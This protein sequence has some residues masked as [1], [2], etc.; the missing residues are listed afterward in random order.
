MHIAIYSRVSTIIQAKKGLS[1]DEQLRKGI[2]FCETNG[3]SYEL[4]KDSGYSGNLSITERPALNE[5]FTRITDQDSKNNSNNVKRIDGIFATAIDRISRNEAHSFAI[6]STLIQKE[7]KYFEISGEKD[8]KDKTTNLMVGVEMLLANFER[9]RTTERV[10]RG[11]E[12]SVIKGRVNSGSMQ[13]YGYTKG[14]DKLLIIDEKESEIVNEIYLMSLKGMGAK[15]ISNELNSRGVP[16]KRMQKEKVI[17]MKVRSIDK[18][19]FLWRDAVIY[20]ILTNSIYKGERMFRGKIYPAPVIIEPNL[21]DAVQIELKKRKHFVNTKTKYFYLLKGLIICGKCESRFFGKKRDDLSDNQYTCGSQRNKSEFCGNRGINID[22]LNDFVW[23]SLLS[24]PNDLRN[25]SVDDKDKYS[26][27]IIKKI[28]QL[29]HKKS[30]NDKAIEVFRRL[31][32]IGDSINTEFEKDIVKTIKINEN[33]VQQIRMAKVQLSEISNQEN[34]I[35]HLEDNLVLFHEDEIS[36][37]DKQSLIRIYVKRILVVW[38]PKI[39]QHI[40]S[41]DFILDN[42]S[43][44]MYEKIIEIKYNKSG[45]RYNENDLTYRFRKL[46]HNLKV[47]GMDTSEQK[48]EIDINTEGLG[49]RL[50]DEKYKE[51]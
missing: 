9:S 46:S 3:F 35:K 30:I 16:T 31:V 4:F 14:K 41:I 42:K 22:K 12:E 17:K 7:I 32:L 26:K 10:L 6:K 2:E 8:L 29:E 15:K 36:D 40:I 44:L 33:I 47:K 21:F 45:W 34:I 23:R 48:I 50:N 11:L 24:L 28:K 39:N 43:E 25:Y 18:D 13:N 37:I 51:G 49:V 5:L 19:V 27:E 38:T 20:R 1:L